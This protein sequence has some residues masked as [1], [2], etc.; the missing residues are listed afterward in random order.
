MSEV[1]GYERIIKLDRCVEE[2][3]YICLFKMLYPL[4]VYI[5]VCMCV[6]GKL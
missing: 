2:S 1:P 5:H 3:I 6:P 4:Y